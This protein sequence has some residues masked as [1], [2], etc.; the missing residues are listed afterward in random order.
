M[1]TNY[2]YGHLYLGIV[3]MLMTGCGTQRHIEVINPVV[4]ALGV[5]ARK[6]NQQSQA[7]QEDLVEYR[8]QHRSLQRRIHAVRSGFVQ[9]GL[10]GS[11]PAGQ[12]VTAMIEAVPACRQWA[13]S[14]Q[15]MISQDVGNGGQAQEEITLMETQQLELAH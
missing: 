1:E 10:S 11:D 2:R 9:V 8:V 7:C 5:Q 13:H 4:D 14:Y 3:L 15:A 12:C 6:L